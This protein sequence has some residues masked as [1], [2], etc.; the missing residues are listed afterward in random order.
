MLG[1]IETAF[2]KNRID[3][4]KIEKPVYITGLARAGSTILLEFLSKSKEAA[5]HRY[6]DFPAIY[7]PYFWGSFLDK[8]L[9]KNPKEQE[10][11]H[12]DGIMITLSSPESM[13]EMLWRS[14]FKNLHNPKKNSILSNN[15]KNDKF[16]KFYKEHL[17][18]IILKRGS[19][20]YISKAN[21]NLTRIPYI[22]KLFPTAK[23]ILLV[24]DPKKHIASFIKTDK[25][26]S[27]IQKKHPLVLSHFNKSAHFEYG[28]NKKPVNCGSDNSDIMELF[29]SGENVRAWAR[30]WSRINRYLFEISNSKELAGSTLLIKY[31]DLCSKPELT[32]KKIID[33]ISLDIS[34]EI[35]DD[36]SKKLRLPTYYTQSFSE[37][38]LAIIEEETSEVARLFGY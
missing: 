2:L 38:E 1:N 35:I 28:L 20:R 25:Y 3:K 11:P 14:F 4:I 21:Y 7:T 13:E 12:K 6:T 27:D 9:P 10:R 16:E 32:L 23:S 26:V 24:R 30:Y 5:T 36:Y 37:T 33:F 19:T 22:K 17:K 8:V 18:K 15:V 34:D 31:E 29:K